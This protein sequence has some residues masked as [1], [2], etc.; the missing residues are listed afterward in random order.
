LTSPTPIRE[1]ILDARN[2][3]SVDEE[4][5]WN[6]GQR[7]DAWWCCRI[8]DMSSFDASQLLWKMFGHRLDHDVDDDPLDFMDVY[9]ATV[10]D[11]RRAHWEPLYG[12]EGPF[13]FTACFQ[14]KRASD[15]QTRWIV[16]IIDKF[17]DW[18][19]G[20]VQDI[21]PQLAELERRIGFRLAEARERRSASEL[22]DLR[23]GVFLRLL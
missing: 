5:L 13:P 14:I 1:G 12:F 16:S 6:R 10:G 21:T 9:L 11:L 3:F 19:F 22:R 7:T 17:E 23:P 8:R 15:S 18:C 2:P 4:T 20:I